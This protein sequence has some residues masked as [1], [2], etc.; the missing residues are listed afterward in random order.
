MCN[1]SL[2]SNF[3]LHCDGSCLGNPGPGGW[4]Y[5]LRSY[6]DKNS[7]EE[8]EKSGYEILT[9]NN[10][11][12]LLAVINGLLVL[13]KNNNI[14]IYSDSQYVV[15]GIKSWLKNWKRNNWYK[16]DGKKVLNCDLW[17]I[18]DAQLLVRNVQINWVR[19]HNGHIENDRVDYLAKQAAQIAFNCSI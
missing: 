14:L 16:S 18:L 11:M 15:N 3:E 4:A 9:T 5:L 10:R 7:F 1:K 2:Y 19:G 8:Q 13:P 12:E 6:I 17:Q